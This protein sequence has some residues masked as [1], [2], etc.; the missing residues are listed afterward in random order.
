MANEFNLK[1]PSEERGDQC[2]LDIERMAMELDEFVNEVSMELSAISRQ[3]GQTP[4]VPNLAGTDPVPVPSKPLS[5]ERKPLAERPPLTERKPLTDRET[6]RK[7]IPLQRA[8]EKIEQPPESRIQAIR[9]RLARVN[10][11]TV[12]DEKGNRKND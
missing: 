8:P 9:D 7:P 5:T 1:E 12:T 4:D 6:L 3:L 11:K 2:G 10:P